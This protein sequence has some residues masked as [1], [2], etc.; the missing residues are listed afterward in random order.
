MWYSNSSLS[1]NYS[2]GAEFSVGTTEVIYT[3]TLGTET[4]TCSFTV[5]V[6]AASVATPVLS[7][8]PS[9]IIVTAACGATKAIVTWT[10]PTAT[11]SCG[12][13]TPSL[14]SNYS[15]GAE[16]SVG[17]TE[18]IYT[19]TLGTETKT[20]SF[21]VTV[22]AAS[23]AT[24]ILT[25]CP[26][27]II[28]TPP[29][30]ATKAIV[31]WTA[32]TATASCGTET[33]TVSSDY[34]SG[35][36]FSVGTTTVTYTAT[37]GT[38][39]KTCSFT[40]T[41]NAAS[42]ATPILSACPEN[43]TVTAACGATKAIVT[44]TAPT[45]TA[46]CGTATPTVSSDY[47]S[48]AEFSV[49]TTT[50]TY[51]ATLG[52]ETKTCS[53][54]VTVNAASVATPILSACPEN[55][56]V[57]AAC[58]ATKAIVTW[59]APTATASC[60]TATP[61]LSSNYS[62][63]AEFSV[64]TTA[65]VTYTATLGTRTATCSFTVTVN[66]TSTLLAPSVPPSNIIQPTCSMPTGTITVV[67]Q[68][69]VTYSFDNGDTY[70]NGNIKSGL[71]ADIYKI[72]VKNVAGCVSTATLVTLTAATTV[73]VS[74]L[75]NIAASYCTLNDLI[76]QAAPAGGVF[77]LDG[78]TQTTYNGYTILDCAFLSIGTHTLTYTV[79][80]NG[81]KTVA[82]KQFE[83]TTNPPRPSVKTTSPAC[84]TSGT[85]TI[86]NLPVGASSRLNNGPW[87]VNKTV[88]SGLSEGN[89]TVS[90]SQ[91]GCESSRRVKLKVNDFD[92]DVTKCYKIVN[93]NS[94]KVLDVSGSGMGNND[95]V[96]Q[97]TLNG[98]HGTANQ[99][100]KIFKTRNGFIK[101]V[102]QHSQKVLA[103]HQTT[104]GANVYQ[105]DYYNTGEK[106]WKI[107]CVGDYFRFKHRESG[108]YLSIE[109]NNANAEIRA[110]A[111]LASQQWSI[112]EVACSNTLN[113]AQ[114]A[115]FTATVAAEPIRIRLN[116]YSN[117]GKEV[118]FYQI[119]KLQE[120]TN[121]FDKIELLNNLYSDED[122]HSFAHF[123]N[124]PQEGDNIYR[125]SAFL[126]DGTQ[127][128]SENLTVKFGRTDNLQVYPN[129][130]NTEIWLNLKVFEGRKAVVKINDA[131]GNPLLTTKIAAI[132]KTPLR[133]E[134]GDWSSGVYFIYVEIEG[135]KAQF[136]KIVIQK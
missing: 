60:G 126:K 38:E 75:T 127:R 81:C 45:A 65:T 52:T 118:D 17:T 20:C 105:H 9:N 63:G 93:R 44:W 129:P 50:V 32:P 109:G 28:V 23:V 99:K 136:Q 64:G 101:L 56:T 3:A 12:T 15:S 116:W 54:T 121:Q 1:S 76:V 51:T 8:C 79:T 78:Q 113:L 88:Y 14:S 77:K 68:T 112:V 55:I 41:V 87:R 22:N 57:T 95:P 124:E 49:G 117:L 106:D 102:A 53:F 11:A 19:A 83:I 36:E 134:I 73:S 70:Q 2:S 104:E 58:G 122:V 96:I 72:K 130:A 128:L 90:F 29:C 25:A 43:I 31:T 26:E 18:V 108:K 24:P 46:S 47:S 100:W 7:A 98:T 67:P 111:N 131:M 92:F 59:T 61:S 135:R 91:N 4:A 119:E 114:K 123:D 110:W 107:E 35:A 74:I 62:S 69:G 66:P 30:G 10:A 94:G 125:I 132:Q 85:I 42:V 89:Y 6:N 120:A 40:V 39:T 33:P 86:T 71:I 80:Q 27:N 82:T 21:T 133:L 37:L 5:T 48:G 115:V 103:C 34:S 97:Y 84:S 13:A 16:F